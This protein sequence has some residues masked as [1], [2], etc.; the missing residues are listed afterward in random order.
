LTRHLHL[1][2]SLCSKDLTHLFFLTCFK[3]SWVRASELDFLE[4]DWRTF[5]E[6]EEP[7]VSESRWNEWRKSLL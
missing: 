2:E 3:S 4:K 7:P 6:S 5:L 1:E